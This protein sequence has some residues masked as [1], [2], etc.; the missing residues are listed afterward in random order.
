MIT[1]SQYYNGSSTSRVPKW[2]DTNI[3]HS[4]IVRTTIEKKNQ[5]ITYFTRNGWLS[6]DMIV[7]NVIRMIVAKW[8]ENGCRHMIMVWGMEPRMAPPPS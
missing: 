1:T 7:D 6:H 4:M 3:I 8:Y 5:N 2:E